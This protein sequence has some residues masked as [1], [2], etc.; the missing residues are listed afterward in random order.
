MT[1]LT[2]RISGAPAANSTPRVVTTGARG[3]VSASMG[4]DRWRGTWRGT[5]GGTWH[6]FT[7]GTPAIPQSP[8]LD[9]TPRIFGAPTANNTKRVTLA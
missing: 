1:T 9:V 3:A 5:W 6:A 2:P 7:E 4:S 8:A